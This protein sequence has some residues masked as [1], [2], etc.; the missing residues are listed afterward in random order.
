[1][2]L[3]RRPENS[4]FRTAIF[5]FNTRNSYELVGKS[6][7]FEYDGS[8][9]VLFNNNILK[10]V[11]LDEVLPKYV[12]LWLNSPPG[13][14]QLD[15]LK[16]STTNVAAIYQGKL[17][18]LPVPLPPTHE[19][20]RIVA[21]VDELMALCDELEQCLNQAETTAARYAEAVCASL[22]EAKVAA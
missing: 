6:C 19:Q 21:K 11:F 8:E 4:R 2:L 5:L 1:M 9:V 14:F 7:V 18:Q 16:S 17:A 20:E 22:T 13:R 15:L 12:N 10:V 3:M